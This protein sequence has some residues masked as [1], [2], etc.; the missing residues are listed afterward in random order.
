MNSPRQGFCYFE[1]PLYYLR[2]TCSL[3][4][5]KRRRDSGSAK[6]PRVGSVAHCNESPAY[7]HAPAPTTRWPLKQISPQLLT[8]RVTLATIVVVCS[9]EV[10]YN[11]ISHFSA[12]RGPLQEA[13]M[14]GIPT[15]TNTHRLLS[16]AASTNATLVK[17]SSGAVH[18]IQGYNNNAA[19]R[20]LKLYDKATAPTVGTDVPRKTIRLAPTANFDYE[21][22]DSYQ[23]GIGYAIT[24]AA[25]DADTGALT[26][27]DIVA[28]N[29][30]Y[31]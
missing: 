26:A 10:C 8:F 11:N 15:A 16:A 1:S 25:A 12:M 5:A 4:K 27:G 2:F 9:N 7:P 31:R 6:P 24:T 3:L 13:Q 22:H 17:G 28:M 19:A 30:D 29:I 23:L 21:L 14:R 18:R 20:F